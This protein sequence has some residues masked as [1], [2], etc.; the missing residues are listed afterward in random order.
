MSLGD[1]RALVVGVGGLGCP[2][3]RVLARSGVGTLVLLDDDVV[4]ATNLHRQVLYDEGDVGLPKTDRAARALAAEAR[5]LDRAPTIE[6]VRDRLLPENALAHLAGVDVVL[7]GADNLASKF[8]A[9]DACRMAGV[10]LV[11][12]GAVRFQG[13]VL[14]TLPGRGP[15]MRCVFEDIPDDRVETCAEAGIFGPVVGAIGALQAAVALRILLGDETVEGELWGYDAVRGTL[16]RTR[17]ARRTDCPLCRG[18]IRD[19]SRSRYAATCA[20]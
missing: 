6:T 16:R 20:A 2:A 17:V 13:W 14:A 19:L 8:L 15:C 11:Q 5:G 18:D 4:D 3:S 7:E 12:A 1:R 9:V 10:P